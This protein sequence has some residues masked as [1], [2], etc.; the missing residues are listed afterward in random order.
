MDREALVPVV[1]WSVVVVLVSSLLSGSL[2][3]GLELPVVYADAVENGGMA[4]VLVGIMLLYEALSYGEYRTKGPVHI[5]IDAALVFA[6]AA[7]VTL[8]VVSG[9]DLAGLGDLGGE[10]AGIAFDAGNVLAA[11]AAF[12]AASALFLSRNQDCY[13]PPS[14][15]RR[16]SR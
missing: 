1:V 2:E 16:L 10:V 4:L 7:V 12:A 6:A 8:V 3:Y 14:A 11:L 5:G 15:D 13:H 9:F